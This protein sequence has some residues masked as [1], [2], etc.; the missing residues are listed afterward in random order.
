VVA[1]DPG[2][3]LTLAGF[4][5]HVEFWGAPVH[6]TATDPLNFACGFSEMVEV[7]AD[8]GA[9]LIVVGEAEIAKFGPEPVNATV[10]DPPVALSL[11]F[12]VA[13]SGPSTL[14]LRLTLTVQLVPGDIAAPQV[15]LVSEKSPLFVPVNVMLLIVKSSPPELL[16]V[17]D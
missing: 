13:D 14:G 3:T 8:P 16:K 5:V 6:A 17:V 15:L 9:T 7:P 4:S 1:T 2:G 12:I 10:C 11:I